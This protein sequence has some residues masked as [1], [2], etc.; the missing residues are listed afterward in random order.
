MLRRIANARLKKKPDTWAAVSKREGVPERTLR[1]MFAGYTVEQDLLE[2]PVGIVSET[3]DLFTAGIADFAAAAREASDAGNTNGRIGAVRSMLDAAK[4]RLELL[5][6]LRRLPRRL[7]VYDEQ[8]RME[9]MIVEMIEV[10]EKHKAEPELVHD[11]IRVIER[12]RGGV[13][14]QK[15][16]EAA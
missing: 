1:Y 3:L 13:I 11:L 8:R 5:S 4:A 2:D 6:A 7:N 10:I 15:A 14:E 9:Q 12:A 16:I